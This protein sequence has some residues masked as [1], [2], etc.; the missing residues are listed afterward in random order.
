MMCKIAFSILECSSYPAGCRV[1]RG[2]TIH[3]RGSTPRTQP[4]P[5][6]DRHSR[7]RPVTEVTKV[8]EGHRRVVAGGLPAQSFYG[9]T[10]VTEPPDS[11]AL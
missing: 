6:L 10:E 8:T 1:R 11:T 2:F 3:A 7:F 9:V 5:P 4:L